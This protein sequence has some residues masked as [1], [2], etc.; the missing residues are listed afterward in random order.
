[1]RMRHYGMRFHV[2]LDGKLVAEF[3]SFREAMAHARSLDPSPVTTPPGD[4]G[5]G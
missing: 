5:E 4:Q 2:Y 1:M 3:S